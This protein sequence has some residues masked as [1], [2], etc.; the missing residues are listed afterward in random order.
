M[1]LVHGTHPLADGGTGFGDLGDGSRLKL[2]IVNVGLDGLDYTV[3]NI[4]LQR[5]GGEKET[6]LSQPLSSM[7]I[8]DFLRVSP[9]GSSTP[10]PDRMVKV[11]DW[12]KKNQMT[13]C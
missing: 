13:A 5:T 8:T 1:V 3:W 10:G 4:V 9:R 12:S 2:V 7:L 11:S 6:L